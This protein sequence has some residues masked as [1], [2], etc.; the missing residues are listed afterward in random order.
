MRGESECGGRSKNRSSEKLPPEIEVIFKKIDDFLTKEE[1][2]NRRYPDFLRQKISSNPA[3]DVV[4]NAAGRFGFDP[5]NPIP[6]NGPIGELFYLSGLHLESGQGIVF[7]RLGSSNNLDVFE[8]MS[9]DGRQWALLFLDM[10]YPRKSVAAPK[11]YKRLERE[12]SQIRF[13][14]GTN[15]R[16]EKF[17][18]GVHA[19]AREVGMGFFGMPFADTHLEKI[20]LRSPQRP[21]WHQKNC[22]ERVIG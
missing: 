7:H 18:F 20:E 2:Q 14:R 3:T 19:A 11:G 17:P 5:T 9:F 15:K 1:E 13:L 4:P 6:V 8:I 10:Y 16:L 22:T 12:R 21:E